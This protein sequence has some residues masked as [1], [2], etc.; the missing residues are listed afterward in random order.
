[1]QERGG[2]AASWDERFEAACR[3][4]DAGQLAA[5]RDGFEEVVAAVPGD[6]EAALYL[7]R[8]LRDL[9]GAAATLERA[10]SLVRT[11][12]DDI[13]LLCELGDLHL[14]LGAPHEA[15]VPLRHAL[16]VAPTSSEVLFL[17]GNAFA[18]LGH[19]AE[20]TRAYH[21]ALDTDPFRAEAWYNLA[22]AALA[23]GEVPEGIHALENYLRCAG[24]AAPDREDVLATLSEL[25]GRPAS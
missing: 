6:R 5:A 14:E 13:A 19:H 1:M 12:P 21:E 15:S 25:K 11:H 7:I 20:A 16:Q 8:A 3:A 17:L 23:V 4:F 24:T 9:E 2:D 10:R 22:L 18:D